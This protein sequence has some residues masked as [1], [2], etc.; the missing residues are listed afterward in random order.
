M[1]LLL[2]RLRTQ[3]VK[4]VFKPKSGKSRFAQVIDHKSQPSGYWA[5]QITKKTGMLLTFQQ[6]YDQ[7]ARR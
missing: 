2:P 7:R 1:R 5:N 4:L 3:L 6:S